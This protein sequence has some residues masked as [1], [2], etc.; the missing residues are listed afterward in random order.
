V[1]ALG[2]QQQRLT[3]EVLCIVIVDTCVAPVES[4]FVH[5]KRWPLPAITSSG[6]LDLLVYEG[7]TDAGGFI[8]VQAV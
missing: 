4:A 6:L 1:P 7:H 5:G 2:G 3:R 8:P